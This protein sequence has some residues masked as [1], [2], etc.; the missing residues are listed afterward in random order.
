MCQVLLIYRIQMFQHQLRIKNM[1]PTKMRSKAI[2]ALF[3]ILVFLCGIAYY[4][5][6]GARE[7]VYK[8]KPL[9]SWVVQ[10]RD[11]ES[12]SGFHPPTDSEAVQAI[13]AIGPR[14]VPHLLRWLP[15]PEATESKLTR[16]YIKL[17]Q[18]P[19]IRKVFF[20]TPRPSPNPYEVV[21]AFRVLGRRAKGAIPELERIANTVIVRD[22]PDV[23]WQSPQ[24][25][26][27]FERAVKSLGCLGPDSVPFM[28]ELAKRLHGRYRSWE[29]DVIAQIGW[30]RTN[31]AA[32]IPD[33]ITWSQDS[34]SLVRSVAI[35]SLGW[36]GK[37][38]KVVVPAL[39]AALRDSDDSQDGWRIKEEAAEALGAF[40]G[41]ARD[42]IPVLINA[43]KDRD[44]QTREAAITSLGAICE[45]RDRDVLAPLL[46]KRL[47]YDDGRNRHAAAAVLGRLGGKVAF[48]AL[49]RAT[50]DP[51]IWVREEVSSSLKRI[52]PKTFES[53]VTD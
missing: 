40:G 1:L 28:V 50:N 42:S 34:D 33:L 44:W 2:A 6:S 15:K 18:V 53:R 38:P 5:F 35:T 7:P 10:L 11:Y 3:L 29:L 46:A 14:A 51:D 47:E 36:V 27:A 4:C 48:D 30:T 41:E 20:G 9:S 23:L 21:L 22:T 12:D 8:G 49:M 13:R 37:E 26:F 31:G 39:I 25:R 45:D 32:A 19:V 17:S 16:L 43:L 52:N 24:D